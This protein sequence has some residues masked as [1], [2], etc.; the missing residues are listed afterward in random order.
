MYI[1]ETKNNLQFTT[2]INCEQTVIF[3]LIVSDVKFLIYVWWTFQM[4][5]LPL[6]FVI[7]RYSLIAIHFMYILPFFVHLV[8]SLYAQSYSLLATFLW[9]SSL[10]YFSLLRYFESTALFS[11]WICGHYFVIH[12][13]NLSLSHCN[14]VLWWC[15]LYQRGKRDKEGGQSLNTTREEYQFSLTHLFL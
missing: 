4:F 9:M 3:A 12:I 13:H 2:K 10:H 15:T 7:F 5:Y 6:S 11:M 14:S 8:Y 1:N